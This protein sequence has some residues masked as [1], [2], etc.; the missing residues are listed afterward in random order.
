M[1][2]MSSVVF[3]Q[4]RAEAILNRACYNNYNFPF[5]MQWQI[6]Q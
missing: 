2:A 1:R 6:V 3:A 4:P 5:H